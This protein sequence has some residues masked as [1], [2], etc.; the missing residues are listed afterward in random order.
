MSYSNMYITEAEDIILNQYMQAQTNSTGT[1]LETNK[2]NGK[3]IYVGLGLS[4][5]SSIPSA[6]PFLPPWRTAV[7]AS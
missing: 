3:D 7:P 1:D 5:L 2:S 4:I 6:D